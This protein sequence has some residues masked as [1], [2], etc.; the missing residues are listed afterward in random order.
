M[1]DGYIALK[2]SEV[3]KVYAKHESA[4]LSED[5]PRRQYE[6][7]NKGELEQFIAGHPVGPFD[8]LVDC[9]DTIGWTD[10]HINS[11]LEIGASS[12]YNGEVLRCAGYDFKYRAL[13][14]APAYKRLANELWPEMEFDIGDALNLPYSIGSFDVVISGCVI[15]HLLDYRRAIAETSRVARHYAVFHRTPVWDGPTTWYLKE[16]YD[17]PMVECHFNE[18]ELLELLADSGLPVIDT[19]DV[20]P[21]EKREVRNVS[22]VCKKEL[23]H[24]P[25]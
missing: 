15:L 13:D 12:G 16:S 23:F 24:H 21:D 7:F 22:Y 4:W 1:P 3:S 2:P 6:R 17:V 14:Y 8:A 9:F 19:I 18:P 20:Y 5:I 10:D 11:V 25:V